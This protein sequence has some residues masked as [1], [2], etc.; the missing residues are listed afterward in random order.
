MT[1]SKDSPPNASTPNLDELLRLEIELQI[2]AQRHIQE[3]SKSSA[4]DEEEESDSLS[5][6]RLHSF[7]AASEQLLTQRQLQQE[8]R[9]SAPDNEES[10]LS[11]GGLHSLTAALRGSHHTTSMSVANLRSI[12]HSA[13][14]VLDESDDE[15]ENGAESS[16]CDDSNSQ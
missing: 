9:N 11:S 6:R 4:S 13:L 12:L 2:R 10:S 8:S 1:F 15:P 5:S 16:S 7:T 3:E 14:A